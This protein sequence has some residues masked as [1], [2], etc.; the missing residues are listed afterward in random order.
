[1]EILRAWNI[2]LM[3]FWSGKKT[4]N[5]FFGAENQR[6]VSPG[7]YQKPCSNT[8]LRTD[9]CFTKINFFSGTAGD[10]LGYHRGMAFST[11][12][13]D[14]DKWSRNCAAR[15]KGGWWYNSCHY[16]NLNGLYLNGKTGTQGMT[17]Y[18]WKNAYYSVKRSEIKI[19]PQNF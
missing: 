9:T 17:W 12:D 16:S 15:D 2:F 6:N 18:H 11:K 19:R 5:E 3:V 10:S 13:R 4:I 7:Y 8:S 14:D 1:M